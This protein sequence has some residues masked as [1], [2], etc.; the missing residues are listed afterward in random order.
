MNQKLVFKAVSI[1]VILFFIGCAYFTFKRQPVPPLKVSEAA[2]VQKQELVTLLVKPYDEE[3]TNTYF[4]DNLLNKGIQPVQ[5]SLRNRSDKSFVVTF[6][7]K[8]ADTIRL[9]SRYKIDFGDTPS[10]KPVKLV[11]K[12]NKTLN[13]FIYLPRE[14]AKEQVILH[15]KNLESGQSFCFTVGL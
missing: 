5:I 12:P 3:K 8:H 7:Q 13:G 9:K 15:L 14:L 11:L 2:F 4:P 6:P 1:F 10:A